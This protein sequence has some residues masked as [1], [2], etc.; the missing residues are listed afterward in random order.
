MK[1]SLFRADCRA[2]NYQEGNSGRVE[3]AFIEEDE[4]F[5]PRLKGIDKK[6]IE[7]I[8]N[9]IM[10]MKSQVTWEDVAGLEFAKKTIKVN[11]L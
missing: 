7:L 10:D 4:D 1:I 5:D 2:K 3:P 6:L 11:F 9:E 8:K